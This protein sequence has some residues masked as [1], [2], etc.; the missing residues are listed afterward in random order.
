LIK[1]QWARDNEIQVKEVK[2]YFAKGR[3][4]EQDVTSSSL[5]ATIGAAIIW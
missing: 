2:P 3:T 1:V 5:E 4:S